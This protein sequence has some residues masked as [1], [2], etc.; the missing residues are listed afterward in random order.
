M[1]SEE[2]APLVVRRQAHPSIGVTSSPL[3]SAARTPPQD[4]RDQNSPNMGGLIADGRGCATTHNGGSARAYL[5]A[6]TSSAF[7]T[8]MS[9]HDTMAGVACIFMR[10]TLCR[11][12]ALV[13]A[14]TPPD[15]VPCGGTAAMP[16][17]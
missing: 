3:S 4:E 12:R 17:S 16:G 2:N 1:A 15:G 5:T 9:P 11:E 10:A 6:I 7:S 8:I 13:A 14:M